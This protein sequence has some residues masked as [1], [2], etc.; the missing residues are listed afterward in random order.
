MG[1]RGHIKWD[2]QWTVLE[3]TW[4]EGVFGIFGV[5][6]EAEGCFWLFPFSVIHCLLTMNH[7]MQ[8]FNFTFEL[9]F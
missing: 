3:C 9:L 1:Q 2:N 4:T 5:L 7:K 8:K 6:G